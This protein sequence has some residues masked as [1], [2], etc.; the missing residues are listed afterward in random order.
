MARQFQI[1]GGPYL[2]DPEDGTE[3]ALPGFGYFNSP[4]AGASGFNPAW[5]AGSNVVIIEG[6]PQ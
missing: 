3:F 4:A 1:P 6:A 2:N 5:A